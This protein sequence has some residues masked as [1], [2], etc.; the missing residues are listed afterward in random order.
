[1]AQIQL[2]ETRMLVPTQY[3]HNPTAE[4]RE[5]EVRSRDITE[6]AVEALQALAQQ[7]PK[8]R[9]SYT[10]SKENGAS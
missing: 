7:L 4:G 2:L 1:M 9:T 5:E 3:R 8:L 10:T 6:A